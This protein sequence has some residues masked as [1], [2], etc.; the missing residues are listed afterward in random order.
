MLVRT[1]RGRSYEKKP[2]LYD[3][4]EKKI[5]ADFDDND[6]I[7]LKLDAAVKAIEELCKPI[8][9]EAS[10]RVSSQP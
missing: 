4:W 7:P 3:K 8:I 1:Y 2:E 6:E 10:Q 9:T 5:W